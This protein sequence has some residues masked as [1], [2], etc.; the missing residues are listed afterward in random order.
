MGEHFNNIPAKLQDH[1]H[2]LVKIAGLPDTEESLELLSRGWLEKQ[3]SF[4][5]ELSNLGLINVEK[6]EKDN[7]KGALVLTY[8]GS[9]VNIGPLVEGKRKA[10]YASIGLREDVPESAENGE[11]TLEED[12]EIDGEVQFSQ[13][14][15]KKSSP[16]Y[17]IAVLKDEVEPA[18]E[19]DILAEATE[20]ITE[21]FVEVNKTMVVD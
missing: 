19:E 21:N 1:V 4:E 11:S 5:T 6:L 16:V 18:E 17:Q 15:I 7:I 8:S 13:G 10:A 14:P 12:I 20:I 2:R 3:E 9:L